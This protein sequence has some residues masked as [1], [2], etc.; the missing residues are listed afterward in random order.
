MKSHILGKDQSVVFGLQSPEL[1][2]PEVAGECHLRLKKE[3]PMKEEQKTE[4]NGVG[5]EERLTE[6]PR[7]TEIESCKEKVRETQSE[8]EKDRGPQR[9]QEKWRT[10]EGEREIQV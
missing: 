9:G 4:I 2:P 1:P 8:T 6:R 3:G 5:K 10:T 7:E